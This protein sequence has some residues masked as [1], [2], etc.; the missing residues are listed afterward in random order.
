MLYINIYLYTFYPPTRACVHFIHDG[1]KKANKETFGVS[2]LDFSSYLYYN[3]IRER[4]HVDYS[5]IPKNFIEGRVL[6]DL[7]YMQ[8]SQKS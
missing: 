2:F 5:K 3:I 1:T 6:Y 4:S 8:S 7:Q